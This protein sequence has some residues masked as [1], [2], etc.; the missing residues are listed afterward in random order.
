LQKV[1]TSPVAYYYDVSLDA[2]SLAVLAG[3]SRCRFTPLMVARPPPFAEF[4]ELQKERIVVSR[5][6]LFRQPGRNLPPLPASG[7][8]H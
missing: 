1:V 2:K 4:A 3:D 5:D 8:F 6:T 7:L